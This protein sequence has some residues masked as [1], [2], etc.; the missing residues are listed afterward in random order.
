[1]QYYQIFEKSYNS[2]ARI[3]LLILHEN[4][5]FTVNLLLT[6]HSNQNNSIKNKIMSKWNYNEDLEKTLTAVFGTLAIIAILVNLAYKGFD[7][8]NTMDAIKDIAGLIV[9]IAVFL[10][11]SKIFS[12]NKKKRFNFNEKFEEYLVEW[13]SHNKYLIDVSEIK[14]P[15]GKDQDVRT[16]EMVCDHEIMFECN[17]VST[18]S[19]K[20]G[21]FLYLPKSEE[22]GKEGGNKFSFKINKSMFKGNS[23]IFDKYEDKKNDIA[24][25]IATSIKM[26]FNNFGISATSSGDKIDV[27]FS[28]LEKTDKNAKKLIEIVEFVKTLFLAIA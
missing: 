17:D 18:Q 19:C 3:Y 23:E 26:E 27:D 13:A 25:R 5:T 21:S 15:K 1:V 20:K 7:L 22:L 10:I 11:A 12:F 28:S 6:I 9:V 4:H 14:T 2:I 24:K 8:E 16:I